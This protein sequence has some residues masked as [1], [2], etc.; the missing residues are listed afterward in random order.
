M[1]KGTPFLLIET[2]KKKISSSFGL[3]PIVIKLQA[4]CDKCTY[5]PNR[6]WRLQGQRCHMYVLLLPTGPKFESVSLYQPFSSC[7]LF[8]DNTMNNCKWLW[9]ILGQ[10]YLKY[11]LLV[12][13]NP[14]FQCLSL[15]AQPFLTYRPTWDK[16]TQWHPIDLPGNTKSQVSRICKSSA[17]ESQTSNVFTLQPAIFELTGH[18]EAKCTE[19][20]Q[21]A[22]NTMK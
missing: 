18:F 19:W 13:P 1:I 12:P 15:Y 10:R 21:M 7:V 4:S 17:F 3:Q 14:R 20:P 22:L 11:V 6:P 5:Y 16:C 8:R 2:Q 9:T